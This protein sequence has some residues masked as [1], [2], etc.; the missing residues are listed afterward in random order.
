MDHGAFVKSSFQESFETF[1]ILAENADVQSKVV[2]ATQMII[3][4]YQ[5]KGTLFIA[6]NGGSAAD[7]QHIAA[8]MVGKLSQDRTP[9]PAFAMTVDSSLLTAV[10]NDYGYNEIFSRQVEGL[11]KP[12]DTFLGITTSGN[13]ENLLRAFRMCR[14]KGVK[15]ILLSGKEGGEAQKQ[16]LAD[17]VILAPGVHTARIQECHIAI[18]HTMCFLTE[19]ALVESGHIQYRGHK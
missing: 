12:Q 14:E 16:N 19:K 13:S 17:V 5:N 6:G 11:M 2:K 7:A 4:S 9:L 15:S 10:G 1:K 18:Y 3:H 8:E